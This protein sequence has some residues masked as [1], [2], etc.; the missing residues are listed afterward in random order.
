M[1]IKLT[2]FA[3]FGILSFASPLPAEDITE[4]LIP[5]GVTRRVGGYRPLRAEMDLASDVV[6]KLPDDLSMPKYGKFEF[7]EKSWLFVLDEP[8]DKPARLFI[9]TN[10]DGDLTNDPE[11]NWQAKT[12]D[13]LTMYQGTGKLDLGSNHLGAIGLYRFD[14]KDERRPQLKNTMMFYIDFGYEYGFQLDGKAF[15]TFVAGTIDPTSRLSIDRDG[16]GRI[17]S[18]LES[19]KLDTPFNFT[20]T[21]Y[22]F[23]LD[24]GKLKL[25]KA[26]SPMEQQRLPPNLAI[27]KSALTFHATT[28]DGT[29]IE[30][31]KHYAGKI[32]MLDFWATWCGPCIAEIPNMKEAYSKWHDQG[33][34]ILGV[35]FDKADME[36][37]IKEFLTERELPWQQIYEGK[38][39]DTSIGTQH[40]VSGIPFVLLVDG[41]THEIIATESQLRGE[42]LSRLI[43]KKL[44]EKR[45][46]SKDWIQSW[47]DSNIASVV[48]DYWW[49][50]EN[51]ELSYE[52]EMTSAYVAK[53]WKEAG[54]D[55]TT[56]VGGHGVVAV[57]KNG[58]G[59]TVMLRTDLDALPVTEVTG[60]PRA[61]KKKTVL[62]SGATTGIMHACG[63]DVHMS[64][65]IAISRLMAANKDKW[66]GTLV[67]VGQPAEERVGGAKRMIADGLFSRFPK[68]DFALAMHC[69]SSMATTVSLRDGF[70]MAN[71]DTVDI[72]I[73]GRGGHGAAPNTTIDPIV[74]AS[75]LVM[76]LQTIVSREVK[77]TE[78]AVITVGSIHA[79]T[80]HN[81]ISDR[82]DL[83]LTV[84][85]YAPEVREQLL[86]AIRR[87]ANAVAAAYGAEAPEIKL[88]EG[89]PALYNHAA[90]NSR[91]RKLY[92]EKLG[93]YRVHEADQVMGGE[94]FS[95][96]GLAGIPSVMYRVGV[97][98]QGRLEAMKKRGINMSLHAPEF[99]PDIDLALPTAIHAMA[100]GAVELLRE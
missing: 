10:A 87:R 57:L 85:S 86:S 2:C 97:I 22:V 37:K 84:R 59:P 77:P 64:N 5:E 11:T 94:D 15:S 76:S 20:G 35:S 52:E 80:K 53:A 69:E 47:I 96:F 43:G 31:P 63:H 73:K 45:E 44:A 9:D 32:V 13:G 61:S 55:V 88:S 12:Q 24:A 71:V 18:R 46:S 33:F 28:M 29:S 75:E 68:P 40:D 51:P 79:G 6:K 56:Q 26:D 42:G 19:T 23:K 83:Q 4:K 34:E 92:E 1:Y 98:E 54:F 90:L 66:H 17:S 93:T 36:D 81:I 70:M 39:W 38:M 89:T 27:G 91:L 99:Y 78:P 16:N 100:L 82:C 62:P 8:S 65:L 25:E 14:P 67:L 49:L 41:D 3:I 60:L 72:A 7:G 48:E 30:F 58:T 21:T 74:Q 50:H 95:E